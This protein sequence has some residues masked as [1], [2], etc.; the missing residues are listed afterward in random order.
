MPAGSKRRRATVRPGRSVRVLFQPSGIRADVPAGT[1]IAAAAR[2]AGVFVGGVCGGAGTCGK[3][4]V[5]VVEGRR[6]R[7]ALACRLRPERPVTVEVP[8]GT[9][10]GAAQILAE[11]VYVDVEPRPSVFPLEEQGRHFLSVNGERVHLRAPLRRCLGVAFDLGTTTLVASLFDLATGKRLAVA[12]SLD[13][14]VALGEDVVSRINLSIADR[15]APARLRAILVAEANRLMTRACASAGLG[16]SSVCD[17][18]AVGNTFMHHSFLGLP[19]RT[20]AESPYSPATTREREMP[21]AALG[22]RTNRLG[23]AF[24]PP[25]VAG[26]LGSDAVAGALA[27]GLDRVKGP[28]LYIDLGTNGELLLAFDGRILGATTAAGPA[29]EGAQ[30]EC[31][32]RAADGAVSSVQLLREEGRAGKPLQSLREEAGPVIRARPSSLAHRAASHARTSS[33][34]N[35]K[36]FKL[37]IETIGGKPAR[38]IAGSGLVDA[39]AA[40]LDAG[41]VDR[42]GNMVEPHPF[43][44]RDPGGKLAV[45]CKR[46]RRIHLSQ[47]DVRSL[48]LAKAAVAAGTDV[49]LDN[50]GITGEELDRVL[51][52]G[53]FGNYLD[54]RSAMRIGLLPPVGLSRVLGLGNAAS[55]GAGMMLVSVDERKRALELSKRIEY[56]E[57]AGNDRFRGLFVDCLAFP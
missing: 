49:L 42:R 27:A 24:V 30:I 46:P 45:L 53:A 36:E 35:R 32:M 9:A 15:E 48:Q 39:V 41:A 22:L 5:L 3:C 1:D 11:G 14:Q 26:F 50:A 12:S 19:V 51:L 54:R 40:L 20:L 10:E 21:A 6:R 31:G 43:V 25:P 47:Q 17:A 8:A 52:A 44:E 55:T 34:S 38:G 18:V 13:P 57:L 7:P 33:R 4:R 23:R 29:F 56:V 2:R 16:A 37:V 28:T